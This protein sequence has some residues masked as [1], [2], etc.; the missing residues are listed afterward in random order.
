MSEVHASVRQAQVGVGKQADDQLS[1]L[2][3]HPFENRKT[4]PAFAGTCFSK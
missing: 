4:I 3:T 1:F 2:F